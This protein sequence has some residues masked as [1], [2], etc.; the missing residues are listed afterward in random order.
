MGVP[1]G[2]GGAAYICIAAKNFLGEMQEGKVMEKTIYVLDSN[3]RNDPSLEDILRIPTN[4]VALSDQ[5]AVE[6]FKGSNPS[7][8]VYAT[9]IL[10]KYPQQ[11]V[12]LKDTMKISKMSALE[13]GLRKR[14][15]NHPATEKFHEFLSAVMRHDDVNIRQNIIE[16]QA[17]AKAHQERVAQG[18][19][20]Y[21]WAV[22]RLAES[23]PLHE[24]KII[25]GTSKYPRD[26]GM[27]ILDTVCQLAETLY[28]GANP[29]AKSYNGPIYNTFQFRF[30]LCTFLLVVRRI[31]DGGNVPQDTR[32]LTNDYYD[33]TYC[34][35]ATYFDGLLSNDKQASSIYVEACEVL[36]GIKRAVQS[37]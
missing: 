6:M 12:I 2:H 16:R 24:K 1:R 26:L 33:M 21:A 11:I 27:K 3:A 37:K 30:S 9:E 35:Y 25:K 15:I 22:R 13:K 29:S 20:Q 17:W 14:L 19:Q 10:R 34:A 4:H 5:A 23:Y 36:R 7:S 8:I 32:K 31:G 18:M 28:R